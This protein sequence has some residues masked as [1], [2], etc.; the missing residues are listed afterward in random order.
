M[1]PLK[2]CHTLGEVR[3]R[4]LQKPQDV[5]ARDHRIAQS[6]ISKLENGHDFDWLQ[7][8]FYMKV[9]GIRN[10]RLFLKLW[11]L[12]KEQE[13]TKFV[14]PVIVGG[15]GLTEAAAKVIELELLGRPAEALQVMA[16]ECE[17]MERVS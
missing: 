14:N 7:V 4:R 6:T 2:D 11:A 5:L 8:G 1:L 13:E 10:E 3:I 16:L 12:G 15:K 9:Y 17:E